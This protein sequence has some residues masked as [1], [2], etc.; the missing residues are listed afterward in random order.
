MKDSLALQT[1]QK[2]AKVYFGGIVV[3]SLM[4]T[5]LVVLIRLVTL[6]GS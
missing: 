6:N 4:I 2:M 3:F 1:K 5:T